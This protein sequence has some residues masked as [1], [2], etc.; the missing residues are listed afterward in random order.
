[1]RIS[2]LIDD[3]LADSPSAEVERPESAPL[4]K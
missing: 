3:A 4:P 2:K 1:V